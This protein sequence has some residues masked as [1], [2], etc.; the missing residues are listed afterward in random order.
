MREAHDIAQLTA[1]I[2]QR[3]FNLN[4]RVLGSLINPARLIKVFKIYG[5]R[6]LIPGLQGGF[7]IFEA[8]KCLPLPKFNE[9]AD[10]PEMVLLTQSMSFQRGSGLT[11]GCRI[12]YGAIDSYLDDVYSHYRRDEANDQQILEKKINNLKSSFKGFLAK[13]NEY[14]ASEGLTNAKVQYEIINGKVKHG[15]FKPAMYKQLNKISANYVS[16]QGLEKV[17]SKNPASQLTE[18]DF[19]FALRDMLEFSCIDD[20]FADLVICGY[21]K[22]VKHADEAEP[23]HSAGGGT[24]TPSRSRSRKKLPAMQSP[25]DAL[26]GTLRHKNN[27]AAHFYFEAMG[28]YMENAFFEGAVNDV[29]LYSGKQLNFIMQDLKK[30]LNN[31]YCALNWDVSRHL[32]THWLKAYQKAY[33]QRLTTLVQT[34]WQGSLEQYAANEGEQT[35]ESLL[36]SYLHNVPNTYQSRIQQFSGL[37]QLANKYHCSK[38]AKLA[39]TPKLSRLANLARR[40]DGKKGLVKIKPGGSL[41]GEFLTTVA[42]FIIPGFDQNDPQNLL[43]TIDYSKLDEVEMIGPFNAEGLTGFGKDNPGFMRLRSKVPGLPSL[44]SGAALYQTRRAFHQSRMLTLTKLINETLAS[45]G[46]EKR[47]WMKFWCDERENLEQFTYKKEGYLVDA[48]HID[49]G[50]W[51]LI[52]KLH[53]MIYQGQKDRGFGA[54]HEKNLLNKFM[55][56][57]AKIATDIRSEFPAMS[58]VTAHIW[59][60]YMQNLQRDSDTCDLEIG[61]KQVQEF[62]DALDQYSQMLPLPKY[63]REVFLD[64]LQSCLSE[65]GKVESANILSSMKSI[66]MGNQSLAEVTDSSAGFAMPQM[67]SHSY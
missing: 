35:L 25:L 67:H 53:E 60:D 56:I 44:V 20:N 52:N 31:Q 19:V 34:D 61:E 33:N 16:E 22:S 65:N 62:T 47:Q 55:S 4:P 51:V 57:T 17:F 1:N 48:L 28:H 46:E 13:G 23:S 38:R 37:Y 32:L 18:T 50:A 8:F 58:Q 42:R 21:L 27:P 54:V 30:R 66:L 24:L 11:E 12:N 6:P 43:Q 39:N 45:T 9:C 59:L 41:I 14:L 2:T 40:I 5:S 15:Y 7:L 36:L 64:A 26:R 3:T 29:S 49:S 63:L 10:W